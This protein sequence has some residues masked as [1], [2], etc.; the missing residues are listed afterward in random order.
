[1]RRDG[2]FATPTAFAALLLLAAALSGLAALAP[3]AASRV[4]RSRES[5][6]ER[7]RLERAAETLLEAL[8]GDPTP[9]TDSPLDPAWSLA[10]SGVD[11]AS[12]ELRDVSSRVN[13]N[14]VR[15][16]LLEGTD[17]ESLLAPGVT[18]RELQQFRESAGLSASLDHYGGFFS[19]GSERFLTGYGWANVNTTD[20]F[21]L[22]SLA[23]SLT[24]SEAK[25]QAFHGKIQGLLADNRVVSEGDLPA[26][27]G[28]EAGALEP[29]VCAAPAWN[30]H[31]LDPFLLTALLSYPPWKIEE[32]ARKAKA[33][34]AANAGGNLAETDIA[35]ILGIPGEH[36]L[37]HYIGL[38][39][40]FWEIR[41]WTDRASL[42]LIAA[43]DPRT[44]RPGGGGRP[45]FIVI[46]R[47]HSP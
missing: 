8:A 15:K 23:R 17:L 35:V 19:R 39:T 26:F 9:K 32:P 7:D 4:L 24:G 38:R 42:T 18:A 12:L 13:P 6:A 47:R 22:R 21:V 43:R 41:A 44:D 30:L 40:W 45:R 5:Q 37:L 2:G 14:Y 16:K 10:A 3:A 11:G 46:E 29:C 28:A 25:A 33:L 36:V 31:F 27:L 20:E 34:L 1:M